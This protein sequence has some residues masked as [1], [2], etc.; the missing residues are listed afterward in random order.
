MTQPII[1]P[2]ESKT[3]PD[4]STGVKVRQ[5]T[6]HP[7]IHHHPFFF[8]PA[9]DDSMRR[10]VFISERTGKPQIF[11]ED[12]SSGN[13]IQL[14]NRDDLGDW[15]IYPSHDGRYVYFCA[16]TGAWRINLE[17][18][19]EELLADFGSVA[20]REAGM[21]G[22]AMGTT[23]L[24][25]CDQWWAVKFNNSQGVACLAIIDTTAGTYEIVLERDTI[26]HMQFCPDDSNL[27][28]YA[29]PLKD[30]VWVINRDGTN[31]RRLY[32]RKQGEWITHESWIP[33]RRELAFMDWP[34]GIRC[35]H[36]DTA[37][38]R[39][40]T[41]FNAWHAICNSDGS[42][43]V[44]DTNFPDIGLQIF[45]PRDDADQS[46]TL[47]FPQA[48][49]MGEHW[50]GPF[51]YEHGPISVYA[52]QHTHPHPS[53]SPDNK[54]IV[55]TSD[56]TGHAQIYEAEIPPTLTGHISTQE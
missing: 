48:S 21:V 10:L 6:D 38:E 52:P 26:A 20:M 37:V 50:K 19:E 11:A 13:L 14:T 9:Y 31:N 22:A 51:P 24:S 18:C 7:S 53:F 45:D 54:Y 27:L 2:S 35:V 43:M 47:C 56:Q 41:S 36:V 42:L 46:F 25:Y 55:F 49:N 23:A 16:G 4:T 32:Q 15:S 34:K 12:R 33:G 30:R 44:A 17:T 8:V 29:G 39:H 1:Y 28:F 40:V 3:L 5:V